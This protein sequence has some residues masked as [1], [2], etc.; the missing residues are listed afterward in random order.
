D[1]PQSVGSSDVYGQARKLG[2]SDRALRR[3]AKVL[4]PDR[5][6]DFADIPVSQE[7]LDQIRSS[8]ATIRTVSR[9]L[10]AVSVETSRD[11][12]RALEQLPF[13]RTS[14]PVVSSRKRRPEL[15]E[16]PPA[17]PLLKQTSATTLNYGSSIHQLSNIRVVELHELGVFGRGVIVGMIDDGFNNHRVHEALKDIDILDEFNFIHRIPSTMRQPWESSG[18]GMH[19]S[20]TLSALAGFTDGSLIGAAFGSSLILAKTEMDSIE[21][22]AEEDLYVEALEWMELLGADIV[23]TSLGYI[24]W[25]TYD[26]LDG[27]TATT[28]RAARVAAQKGVLLVTAMGNEGWYQKDSTGKSIPGATGTLIAP[29]DADSI[30]AVGAAFSFGEIASFSSTGPTFD[31][32]IKPE[33]VA[34]GTGVV[35]ANGGTVSGY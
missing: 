7:Y 6:I 8:G 22:R 30:I 29:A 9:W 16:T 18:Q 27:V 21:V 28:S 5:L 19:G 12:V 1:K 14:V 17:A 2:I 25:Y 13:V 24:D 20:L 3:R 26:S 33:V 15:L 11:Q 10:N 32:R 35:S 4:P 34:Q 23:S 31:G